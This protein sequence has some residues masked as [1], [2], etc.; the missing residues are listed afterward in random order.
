MIAPGRYRV[1]YPVEGPPRSRSS[2]RSRRRADLTRC[3]AQHRD[4]DRYQNVEILI[5]DNGS[6][7]VGLPG[8]TSEAALRHRVIPYDRPFNFSAI[9]NFGGA[10]RQR[11]VPRL[12]QQRH[13]SDRA[14]LARGDARARPASRGRRGRRAALPRPHDPARGRGRREAA[15][16]AGH[17]FKYLPSG[18]GATSASRTSCGTSARSPAPA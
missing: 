10:P 17:A 16:F 3:V 12:P 14:R 13:G 5:L 7:E 15:A 9:N 11:G 8:A 1:R 6:V 4:A 18:T 2:S